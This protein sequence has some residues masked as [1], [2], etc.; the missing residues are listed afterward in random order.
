LKVIE[1]EL[2]RHAFLVGDGMTI[3]DVAAYTYLAHAPEGN[4]SLDAYPKVRDWLARIEV[5][6]ALSACRR[7]PLDWRRD[8]RQPGVWQG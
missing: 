5:C 1:D 4:V 6:P 2:S 7:P 3:A 8:H